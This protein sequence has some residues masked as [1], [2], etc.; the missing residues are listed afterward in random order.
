MN[1][2]YTFRLVRRINFEFG[3]SE[4]PLAA[5]LRQFQNFS[6]PIDFAIAKQIGN[7]VTISAFHFHCL[8]PNDKGAT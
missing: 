3:L 2:T 5:S 7:S 8:G 1:A 4:L 6:A